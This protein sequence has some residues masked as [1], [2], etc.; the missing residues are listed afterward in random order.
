[1]II[2]LTKLL[3]KIFFIVSSDGYKA[4]LLSTKFYCFIWWLSI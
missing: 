2:N 3:S 1:M 4:N